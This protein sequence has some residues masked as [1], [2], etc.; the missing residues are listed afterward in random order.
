MK[1]CACKYVFKVK[2]NNKKV[3]VVALR[4]RQK[5][6]IQYNGNYAEITTGW[7]SDKYTGDRM[8][9]GGRVHTVQKII[10]LQRT[11]RF[12]YVHVSAE[13]AAKAV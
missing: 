6:N 10:K 11:L 9:V 4:F 8:A 12:Q 2:K 3:R 7:C 5:F 13:W 1:A